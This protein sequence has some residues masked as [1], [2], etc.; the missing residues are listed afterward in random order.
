[1]N[2]FIRSA[3]TPQSLAQRSRIVLAAADGTSNQQ[4]ASALKVPAI[5]VGKWRRC[6]LPWMALKVS[7]MRRDPAAPQA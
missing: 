4:I 5:T 3:S 7:V 6:R 2:Q 1:L